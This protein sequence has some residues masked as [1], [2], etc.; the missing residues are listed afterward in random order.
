[1]ALD[2][3]RVLKP[4]RKLRKLLKNVP[5]QPSPEQVHDLRTNTR[6]LEAILAAISP[7]STRKE[8]S[9]LRELAAIRK[10]AGKVRDMDVLT[11]FAAR[12]TAD[13]EDNCKVRLIENLGAARKSHARKLHRA[14][15]K[16]SSGARSGLKSVS[17][18]LE[19]LLCADGKK[20]DCDPAEAPAQATASALKLE[21]KLF[22]PAHLSRANLHPYRLRVKELHNVLRTGENDH[23]HDFVQALNSVKDSIGEWHDWEELLAIAKDV[24]DHGN[25]KLLRELKST[26]DRKYAEALAQAES[27]RKKYLRI[28]RHKNS[29]TNRKG[30]P[31][32]AWM[33]TTSLAA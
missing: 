15:T 6:R 32:P 14:I 20:K 10:R 33:A 8:K 5:K 31:E 17:A 1:M 24:L 22:E 25:C 11:D 23:N 13:G 9:L 3:K 29:R 2:P 4:A 16:R 7:D 19:K 26:A 18:R 28:D 21:S 12:I 30:V 27:M